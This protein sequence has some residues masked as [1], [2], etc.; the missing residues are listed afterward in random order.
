MAANR[1]TGRLL[2]EQLGG[3][4]RDRQLGLKLGDP[5]PCRHQ[6]VVLVAAQAGQQVLCRCGSGGARYR[7]IAR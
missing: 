7:S 3:P 1:R 6:F 5:T 2:L 4:A